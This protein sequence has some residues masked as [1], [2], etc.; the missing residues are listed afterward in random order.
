MGQRVL[1]QHRDRVRLL[2]AGAGGRPDLQALVRATRRQ[3][4]RHDGR[5][6]RGERITVTEPGGLIGGERLDDAAGAVGGGAGADVLDELRDVAQALLPGDRQQ[7]R[8]DEVLLARLEHDRALLVPERADPVE[9]GR[10]EGHRGPTATLTAGRRPGTPARWRL[11]A[12]GMRSSGRTSSA[13]PAWLTAPGMPQTTEVFWSW[14]ST[15]PP[16]ARISPA[17]LRPSAP[18]PVR[19]TA[20]TAPSKAVTAERKRESTAGRQKFSGGPWWSPVCGPL[21]GPADRTAR[22][23]SRGARWTVPGARGVPSEAS[24]TRSGH[25][26]SRRWA[27]CLVNTGGMCCTRSTGSEAGNCGRTRASA[28]GP[29][30]EE[31]MTRTAGFLPGPLRRP[32]RGGGGGAAALR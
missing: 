25:N 10:G 30:V 32:A 12:S 18:M 26:R 3:Q 1:E 14:T 27:N 4:R 17:P 13:Y 8:L 28:S 2:A 22:W 6:Q 20:R 23:W 7:S 16:A 19:T 29:P 15:V 11:I 9:A 31:P 21:R 5:G 24:T